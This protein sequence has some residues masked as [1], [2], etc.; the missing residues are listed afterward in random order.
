[1]KTTL[2]L[3]VLAVLVA[4]GTASANFRTVIETPAMITCRV[5]A[6]QPVYDD[7]QSMPATQLDPGDKLKVAKLDQSWSGYKWDFED[8]KV[9]AVTLPAGTELLIDTRTGEPRYLIKKSE[10]L[11]PSA[12]VDVKQKK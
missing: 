9:V 8:A 7:G 2:I 5:D 12:C 11:F 4:I 10:R 6:N 3:A 1:M